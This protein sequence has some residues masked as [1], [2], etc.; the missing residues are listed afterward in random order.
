ME[1]SPMSDQRQDTIV[2]ITER[3]RYRVTHAP[4]GAG[5]QAVDYIDEPNPAEATVE[6]LEVASWS[7]EED[8]IDT[9]V[10]TPAADPE[11]A[12]SGDAK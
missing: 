10:S 4:L 2:E 11:N 5:H 9:S 6:L 12:Q 1:T 8:P 3:R 7:T